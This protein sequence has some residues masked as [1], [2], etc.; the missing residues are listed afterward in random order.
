MT[1]ADFI[2][3]YWNYYLSLE[4]RMLQTSSYV[5]IDLANSETFSNEYA[6]LVQAIGGELDA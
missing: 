4:N 5:A 2:K 3:N 6:I 1:R